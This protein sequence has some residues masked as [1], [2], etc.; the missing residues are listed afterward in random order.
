MQCLFRLH[1]SCLKCQHSSCVFPLCVITQ[2]SGIAAVCLIPRTVFCYTLY[3][4]ST[5]IS[6]SHPHSP[7]HLCAADSVSLLCSHCCSLSILF[8]FIEAN[9][10]LSLCLLFFHFTTV[11]P[12]IVMEFPFLHTI[13][14]SYSDC[15]S[16]FV[17]LCHSVI[18]CVPGFF[19]Y[20][21]SPPL[22]C[23]FSI[24]SLILCAP[25]FL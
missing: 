11:S 18:L 23:S 20:P 16:V 12:N 10:Y 24:I 21:S 25:I 4:A 9:A 2:R 8:S 13:A 5:A 3:V 22:S 17:I 19:F 6:P 7:P 1:Q 15:H 14:M